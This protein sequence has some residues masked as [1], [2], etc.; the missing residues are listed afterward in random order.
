MC[1]LRF[2][3]FININDVNC[4][5]GVNEV[6][7]YLDL[8]FRDLLTNFEIIT[9]NGI[10]EQFFFSRIRFW[11]SENKK[12][13]LECMVV[14]H[15][16]LSPSRKLFTQVQKSS[17]NVIKIWYTYIT[18]AHLRFS[19]WKMTI[20]IW[21]S[22]CRSKPFAHIRIF[23]KYFWCFIINTKMCSPRTCKSY[24]PSY[25]SNSIFN[26]ENF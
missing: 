18:V 14:R 1:F 21:G 16:E 24:C 22:S 6:N 23:C 12:S 25:L 20:R 19:L 5:H 17:K 9:E 2:L 11:A 26:Y 15:Q 8:Y 3:F 10:F 4:L 7:L 13:E